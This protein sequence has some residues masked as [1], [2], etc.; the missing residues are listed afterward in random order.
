MAILSTVSTVIGSAFAVPRTPSVPKSFR[1]IVVLHWFR[2]TH[3]YLI[4]MSGVPSAN[5]SLT[6]SETPQRASNTAWR[7]VKAWWVSATS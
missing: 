5:A 2:S 6:V 4:R 1:V 7:S 3:L